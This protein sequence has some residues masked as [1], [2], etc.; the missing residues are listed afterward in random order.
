MILNT[1][2]QIQ[3]LAIKLQSVNKISVDTE[4]YWMRTYY[5]ILCLIQIATDDEFFLL[6]TLADIDF[7]PLKAVFEDND[8]QKIMHSGSNDIPIIKKFLDCDVN[9]VFDTQVAAAFLGF[10]SQ[11][12]L[13]NLLKEVLD[14]EMEKESQF[15]DWR[16]RPLSDKQLAYAVKDVEYLIEL[17]E[18]LVDQVDAKGY[19]EYFEEELIR[20]TKTQ[21][22]SIDTI[23][24]RV[25]N[26]QKF[27]EKVQ[28]S[29]ILIATWREI[30]AQEK[31]I[32]VKFIFDNKDLYA[33]AH[34]NPTSL[35]DFTSPELKRLSQWK[36]KAIVETLTD[37]S[38]IKH[39]ISER[40]TAPKIEPAVL[41]NIV[42]FFDKETEEFNFDSSMI[43]SRKDIR[44]LAYNLNLQNES[45]NNKLLSGWR[46]KVIGKKLKEY[47]LKQI[48]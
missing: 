47:I 48:K 7:S 5:P 33:V 38:N 24:T 6:D 43:A 1:N 30:T 41:N 14:I 45:I 4:F 12:S 22:N 36:K 10:Q 35:D 26:I 16:K 9:N 3:D 21:F 11:L 17:S 28:K 25:G 27:K 29:I 32:P 15:S 44:S 20:V 18:Y 8:I 39:L 23:H 2:K 31:D 42:E 13:K 37:D 34:L 40:K 19:T 46:N